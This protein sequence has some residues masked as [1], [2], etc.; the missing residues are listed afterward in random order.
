MQLSGWLSNEI[1]QVLNRILAPKVQ[2]SSAMVGVAPATMRVMTLAREVG[3][4]I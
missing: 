3:R 4:I 2:K 1:V